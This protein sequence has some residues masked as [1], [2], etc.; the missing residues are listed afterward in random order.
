MKHKKL[1]YISLFSGGGG[2]DVGFEEAGFKCIVA[3]DIASYSR[4][5]FKLNWP[6]VPFLLDDITNLSSKDFLEASYGK[7]PDIIVGGPPCQGFSIMGDKSSS[8]IRNRLFLSYVRL[9]DELRPKAFIFE[10]VR[11]I[12]TMYGGRF[13]NEVVNS[14]AAVGYNV[15]YKL[16]N[17]KNFGVPQNRE[18]IFIIGTLSDNQF[19]FPNEG[20][21]SFKSLKA[22][23]NVSE[24]ILDLVNKGSDFPNHI[25][26]NHNEI[27]VKR[28]KFIK[29]GGKLPPPEELPKEIRR[30]NFGN[31]YVRLH[32]EKV[33]PTMVPGN[34][35]FPIHPT[36]NRS[37][38][39]REA[40]RIQTFPDNIIFAGPRREQ[41]ILVGNAVPP[42][43]AA[44]LA[45][46]TLEHL[47]NKVANGK[48]SKPVLKKNRSLKTSKEKNIKK[49]TFID[50]FAGAGGIT[51]GFINAGLSPFLVADNMR[52]AKLSHEQN[53]PDIPFEFGDLSKDS[54]KQKIK[55]VILNN[56]IDL[57]ILVG[58]PP[59]QGFSIFGKRR[60]INT[61]NYD[62]SKDFRNNLVSIFLDYAEL[63]K[64]KWIMIEN[65]PGLPSLDKGVYIKNIEKKLVK[66]G[67][68]NFEWKII[69]CADYGAPQ[70]RKRFILLANR[71]DNLISWPKAKFFKK[72]EAWQKP[73]RSINEAILNID[74]SKSYQEIPNHKPMNHS[75]ITIKRF[76]YIKEGKKLNID[77]LPESLRYS[78]SGKKIRNYSNIFKRLDRNEPSCTLVPGHSAFPIHPWLDRQLTVREAARIQTFPDDVIFLGNQS[79]QCTQVGNAFPVIVAEYFANIIE[80]CIK[81][82]WTKDNTSSLAFYSYIEQI[83][84]YNVS[85]A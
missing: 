78:R 19:H 16:L 20:L 55:K 26:L 62:T 25:P 64:P 33:A 84:G 48:I 43:L 85:K 57:D 75:K 66:I 77:E 59:C 73:Y 65:V 71:T 1:T 15:H 76:S 40:A 80:K 12:K 21:V 17:A 23:K 24:A 22:K 28:Y 50:L 29:E 56:N 44:K 49:L 31:T 79:E 32:R 46:Q 45:I 6:S 58:G 13:F 47:N 37:L 11:G 60:F 7:Y 61:K 39:P 69:N 14:F 68:E 41:C 9:V 83:R 82:N 27:V 51:R 2:L 74:N 34:N 38:T 53:Y 4:D 54:T 5:T 3:N 30:K 70:L 8:D 35:A 10:N 18:R 67:Y 63:I 81:N 36:L 42:L 72:P 52:A